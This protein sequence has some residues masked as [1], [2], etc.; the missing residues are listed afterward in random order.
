[1]GSTEAI[2]V[3]IGNPPPS[4][5][6]ISK[7]GSPNPVSLGG[8]LTYTILVSNLGPSDA[9]DVTVT[10]VVPAGVTFVSVTA[11]QGS[12]SGTATVTC[13]L[14]KLSAAGTATITL[15]VTPTTAGTITNTATVSGFITD[16][17]PGNNSATALT[18]VSGSADLSVSQSDAPD[19]VLV[20]GNL[21]YTVTATNNGPAGASGVT[22]S[23]PLPGGV[24]FISASPSQ[25]SCS[26]TATVSCALGAL[27]NGA[28]ATVIIVVTPVSAG[29]LSNTVS[30][31]AIEIDPAPAN[32][33]ATVTTMANRS[34]QAITFG[35]LANKTFGDPPFI[36]SAT[37]SSG[38]PVAFAAAGNCTVSASTV[39]L[40][41]AGSCTITASQ[42]GNAAYNP[43]V[44]VAQSFTIG[45]RVP[46]NAEDCK[47]GGWRQLRRADGSEF[48][49][50]G[51][52]IQYVNTG[53]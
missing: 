27:A 13:T 31:A 40:T 14:G 22:I 37:A 6:S 43:A 19:P 17:S 8:N 26:G 32:N 36:V 24:T 28:S 47:N 33:S 9:L 46:T 20:G 51:D 38:L 52:C 42:G 44:S 39:A 18:T 45:L 23:D 21:T 50:Q 4:D 1:V 25:G 2:L 10:D 15:I 29:S 3:K 48:K 34:N 7:V 16:T 35:P 30:V 41:G 53:K 5:L 49:N 11:S 12:C